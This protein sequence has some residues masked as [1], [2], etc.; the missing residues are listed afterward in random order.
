MPGA[1]ACMSKCEGGREREGEL[2][3]WKAHIMHKDQ[4]TFDAYLVLPGRRHHKPRGSFT[5]DVIFRLGPQDWELGA[6]DLR[7]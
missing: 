4:S 5:I 7:E 2:S 3:G 1:G 6:G